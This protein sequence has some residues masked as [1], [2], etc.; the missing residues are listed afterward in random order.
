MT[1]KD[2][3]KY[4]NRDFNSIRKSMDDF[5]LNNYPE[6]SKDANINSFKSLLY[7]QIALIGAQLSLN[8]DFGVNES[9]LST[10][11]QPNN[12]I[13]HGLSRGYKSNPNNSSSGILTFYI[14]I[15]ALAIG[16]GPDT[17]YLPILKKGSELSSIDGNSFIL[18]EDVNFADDSNQVVVGEVNATTGLATSYIVRAYGYCISGEIREEYSTVGNFQKFLKI[19]L[20]NKNIVEILLV[21][22]DEGNEYTEVEY[23]S[24]DVVFKTIVNRDSGTN[25]STK[26]ILK[27][28]PVPRRFTVIRDNNRTFLQ[29]GH[30]SSTEIDS[31]DYLDPSTV[32]LELHAKDHITDKAFDP[33]KLISS[34]KL[35][36]API[37]TTLR[38]LYRANS[39]VNSNA[40]K[41]SVTNISTALFDFGD[42]TVLDSSTI[43]RVRKSLEVDNDTDIVGDV[44]DT[45]SEE[46]KM[47]IINHFS[48]QNRAVTKQDY[49]ALIYAMPS[50]LGA[51]KRASITVGR[52]KARRKLNIYLASETKA[53]KF[54]EPNNILKN[55]VRIWLNNK[56]MINDDIDIYNAKIVNIGMRFVVVGENKGSPV[57]L[58]S[59][60]LDKLNKEFK[61]KMHIGESFDIGNLYRFINLIPG[62]L[63]TTKIDIFKKVGI[64]YSDAKFDIKSNTTTDGR[65]IFVPDDTVLEIKYPKNDIIGVIK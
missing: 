39:T 58:Y 55:N 35:G 26:A 41:N 18:A 29:F 45:N 46:T 60:I 33:S 27:P 64:N 65:Y 9:N 62:V 57:E 3:I 25:E 14:S 40:V 10:A 56:K 63:D 38:I 36:I 13:R 52:E 51:I 54:V 30:G 4:T 61:N 42:E 53:G 11:I 2:S 44:V 31:T 7:D 17:S 15:P 21:E 12:I 49:L 5:E 37:N 50:K 16:I 23:L 34:D 6:I 59:R 32:V 1:K 43:T 20:S 28:V 19:A 48:T 22:D 8:L 24:Q 47:K